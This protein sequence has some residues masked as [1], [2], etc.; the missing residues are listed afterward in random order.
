MTM[1]WG[2]GAPFSIGYWWT[3][4]DGRL[5]RWQEW[6]G[7][8]K[9]PNKGLRLTDSEI[10]EGIVEREKRWGIR[11]Q[12]GGPKVG[13][14]NI[15]RRLRDVEY[16][17]SP[18]CFSKKPDYKGGGQGPSTAEVFAEYDI[19]GRPGDA[20]RDQKVRQFHER[21]RVRPGERPMIQ[22]Y[23]VCKQFIRTIPLLQQDENDPE[24][25]DTTAED[26]VY[27]E[28]ALMCMARPLAMEL[29]PTKASSYDKR[30]DDLKTLDRGTYEDHASFDHQT[31]MERLEGTEWDMLDEDQYDDGALVGT[32][33]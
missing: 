27:D 21:L 5:Y 18:D 20:T 12:D 11:S 29:P 7:W 19:I 8:T 28:A 16:I 31:E 23:D 25:V 4:A 14:V 6:Y 30:L 22:I 3:D 32:V 2:F 24:D 17:L 9:I 1:D 26:H 13:E 15:G 33:E 10:A